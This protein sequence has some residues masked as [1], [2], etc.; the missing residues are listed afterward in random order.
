M[1]PILRVVVPIGVGIALLASVA[2]ADHPTPY[3]YERGDLPWPKLGPIR[4]PVI[5]P[6]PAPP[7]IIRTNPPP[8]LPQTA[9][10]GAPQT[11]FAGATRGDD[12]PL[13]LSERLGSGGAVWP[14][15]GRFAPVADARLRA[16]RGIKRTIRLLD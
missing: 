14:A 15:A 12:S 6:L 13:G 4:G 16:E 7:R 3:L 5:P 1:R 11:E 2:W 9:S 10:R 8:A